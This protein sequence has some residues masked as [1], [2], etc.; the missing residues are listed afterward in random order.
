M[1]KSSTPKVLA[2]KARDTHLKTAP[3]VAAEKVSDVHRKSA[4]KVAAR[5]TAPK[6]AGDTHR[7]AAP[8]VAPAKTSNGH[9]NIAPRLLPEDK[10]ALKGTSPKTGNGHA[11]TALKVAS[12]KSGDAQ[13]KAAPKSA[14]EKSNDA[15][16]KTAIAADRAR[17]THR[18]TTTR[19]EELRDTQVPDSMRALAE[20]NVAQARD[21]YERSK[22]AFRAV[23]ES[24]EKSLGGA[25]ALNCKIIDMAEHN[26]A[27]SFDLAMGLAGAKNLVEAV[28]LQS[29][30]WRKLFRDVSAQA[31]QVRALS[32]KVSAEVAQPVKAQL[33]GTY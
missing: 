18:K 32:I 20:K 7:S 19:F 27:S 11:K 28:E 4:P 3:K 2:E 24:W 17:D 33:K 22:N 12:E 6:D 29:A 9:P 21:L 30:Y 25:V 31:E 8:K 13:P 15:H 23:L 5:E 10:A 1:T 26:I 16:R 14:A